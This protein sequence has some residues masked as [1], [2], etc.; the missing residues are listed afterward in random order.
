MVIEK[1]GQYQLIE[2]DKSLVEFWRSQNMPV[3]E[4]DALKLDW[5]TL[6]YDVLVSNLPYQIS[7]SI[8]I[9]RSIDLKPC[10]SMILMFQKEVAQRIR[11]LHKTDD[12]SILS[13]IAQEFWK[14]ET[15]CD[16]GMRDFNPAPKVNSRVLKFRA[17][18]SPILNRYDYLKFIKMCFKQRRRILKSNLD[19]VYHES[20][21]NWVTVQKLSDKV[22]AEEL[23]IEQLR[24]L[25]FS[26]KGKTE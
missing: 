16:A 6:S 26:V 23:S 2:L 17:K 10:Q 3:I 7:S 5:S 15:V 9:D 20:F 11:A 1:F 12:Y 13:V 4:I 18:Q 25:Y 8:V 24:D 21:N 19:S 14:I 22:R